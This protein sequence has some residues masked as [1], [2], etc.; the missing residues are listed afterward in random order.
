MFDWNAA[1]RGEKNLSCIVNL[2]KNDPYSIF[3]ALRMR[4]QLMNIRLKQNGQAKAISA[5]IGLHEFML[6]SDGLAGAQLFHDYMTC[7]K[8]RNSS[9]QLMVNGVATPGYGAYDS[10]VVD[11][12]SDLQSS[13]TI[14]SRDGKAALKAFVERTPGLLEI[15]QEVLSH[16][17]INLDEWRKYVSAFHGLIADDAM[18]TTFTWHTDTA[19][20]NGIREDVITVVVQCTNDVTGMRILGCKPFYF[21]AAGHVAVFWGRCAHQSIPWNAPVDPLR[22]V[23]KAIF[24]LHP[25]KGI[26]KLPATKVLA[27]IHHSSLN[28]ESDRIACLR[29][30]LERRDLEFE[31]CKTNLPAIAANENLD[32][33]SLTCIKE[34]A[35]SSLWHALRC[36]GPF[37]SYGMPQFYIRWAAGIVTGVVWYSEMERRCLA[38]LYCIAAFKGQGVPLQNAFCA[39]LQSLEFQRVEAPI[40]LCRIKRGPWLQNLGW[41]VTSANTLIKDGD[42]MFLDLTVKSG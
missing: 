21:T 2:S 31:E 11:L 30:V 4:C 26:N 8:N 12:D 6:Q 13:R 29:F 9:G 15:L 34:S 7:K 37:G 18:Q 39:L 5:A 33:T 41:E 36:H 24:F 20:V 19:D 10:I 42:L 25:V 17:G 40:A 23:C 16:F 38:H 22:K 28:S 27:P 1:C 3:M 14:V 32:S 35:L